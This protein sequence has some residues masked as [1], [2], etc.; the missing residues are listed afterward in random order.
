MERP[1]VHTRESEGHSREQ[2]SF[3][4]LIPHTFGSDSLKTIYNY[5]VT[6]SQIAMALAQESINRTKQISKNKCKYMWNL[7]YGK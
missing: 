2:S 3:L 5:K 4:M 1:G 6:I 7:T